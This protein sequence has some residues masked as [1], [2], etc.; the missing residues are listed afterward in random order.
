M[1][2]EALKSR[3]AIPHT[4][5]ENKKQIKEST[6]G[7]KNF[8]KVL[9]QTSPEIKQKVSDWM[10][11]QDERHNMKL[12][13]YCDKNRHLVCIPYSIEN[14]HTMANNL[15]IHRDWFHKDHYDIPV[16]RTGEIAAKSTVIRPRQILEII[17]T[18]TYTK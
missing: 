16:M 12:S 17:K 7:L 18:G 8:K 11:E 15:D 1:M 10:D 5:K 4:P 14:L 2:N 13:Y 6:W 9:E 3:K